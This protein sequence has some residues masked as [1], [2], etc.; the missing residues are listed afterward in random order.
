L[1]IIFLPSQEVTKLSKSHHHVSFL[2][3]VEGNLIHA[4]EIAE[5][6]LLPLM[7]LR[8][9]KIEKKKFLKDRKKK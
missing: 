8:Q 9:K 3:S 7:F 5:E 6:T 4:L 2:N 1:I